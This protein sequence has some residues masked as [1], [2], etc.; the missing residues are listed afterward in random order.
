MKRDLRRSVVIGQVIGDPHIAK[1]SKR[2][3]AIDELMGRGLCR[4]CDAPSAA[5]RES[6]SKLAGLVKPWRGP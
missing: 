5:H 2:I 6:G 3:A 1:Y 4:A